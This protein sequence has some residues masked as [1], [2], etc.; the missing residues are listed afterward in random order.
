MTRYLATN[1]CKSPLVTKYFYF[2]QQFRG[3][4]SIVFSGLPLWSAEGQMAHGRA[5]T[6][7]SQN[8]W[9][10]FPSRGTIWLS[11]AGN[12]TMALSVAWVKSLCRLLK[13]IDWVPT[14]H[15][16]N[17]NTFMHPPRCGC[18]H[19][20]VWSWSWIPTLWEAQRSSLIFKEQS[21]GEANPALYSKPYLAWWSVF[22]RLR[23]FSSLGCWTL[24]NPS[25]FNWLFFIQINRW[26]AITSIGQNPPRSESLQQIHLPHWKKSEFCQGFQWSQ[27]LTSKIFGGFEYAEAIWFFF[28]W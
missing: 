14:G 17:L 20:D 15:N 3:L 19:R 8:Q 18:Q 2:A 23:P 24:C 7:L 13:N 11:V 21:L 16:G 25:S 9:D 6:I 12:S 1:I 26:S 5:W 10:K 27:V 28:S 22:F 4:I